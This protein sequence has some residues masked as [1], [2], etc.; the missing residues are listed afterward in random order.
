VFSEPLL[1]YPAEIGGVHATWHPHSGDDDDEQQ[2]DDDTEDEQHMFA[3]SVFSRPIAIL[4]LLQTTVSAL[5]HKASSSEAV[6]P[7][8]SR[9]SITSGADRCGLGCSVTD[10]RR[11]ALSSACLV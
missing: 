5:V 7:F 1:A 4:A 3:E 9:Q 10:R 2:R 11:T 6:E 8:D